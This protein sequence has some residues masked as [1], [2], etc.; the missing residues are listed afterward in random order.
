MIQRKR[1][2]QKSADTTFNSEVKYDDKNQRWVAQRTLTEQE[3]FLT[4]DQAKEW[5][6]KGQGAKPEAEISNPAAPAGGKLPDPAKQV[7]K[8]LPPPPGI[9]AKEQAKPQPSVGLPVDGKPKVQLPI[10]T[11]R[12]KRLIAK[13]D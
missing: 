12:K 13:E 8:Q 4:E 5:I 11:D 6:Q 9:E 2:V 1:L 7:Q 10:A 3:S